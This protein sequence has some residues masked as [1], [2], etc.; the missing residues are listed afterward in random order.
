VAKTKYLI[1]DGGMVVGY[2]AKELVGL[3]IS[4]GELAIFSA[5]SAMPY[6]RPPLSK[7]SSGK[8]EGAGTN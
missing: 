4:G 8:D 2:A 3:G 6:E 5:D 7:R 1:L